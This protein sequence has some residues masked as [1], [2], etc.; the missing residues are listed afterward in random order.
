VQ[1]LSTTN[2]EEWKQAVSRSFGAL[3]QAPGIRGPVGIVGVSMGGT[4]ALWLAAQ[5][6]A[7]VAA[8]AT[9]GTPMFL[10]PTLTKIIGWAERVRLDKWV[11]SLPKIAG[12]DIADDQARKE[13]P[14]LPGTPV[15][16]VYQFQRL[17]EEVREQLPAV[18]APL[19]LAHGMGDRTV[20]PQNLEY[21]ANHTGSRSR[22]VRRY[23]ASRHLLS[24][25]K[26][27][28]AVAAGVVEF[29]QTQLGAPKP[30]TV[31]LAEDLYV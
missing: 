5:E 24:L 18:Q 31:H 17:L 28:D 4:L 7:R 8:V 9:L 22:E 2:K 13:N 16:A 14:T 30:A 25:D 11:R 12:S 6:P 23:P 21:L 15:A 1:E 27:R 29:F 3:S 19:W 20:P 10:S 26:D